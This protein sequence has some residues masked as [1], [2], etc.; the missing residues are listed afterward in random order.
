[1]SNYPDLEKENRQCE[2]ESCKDRADCHLNYLVNGE[3]STSVYCLRHYYKHH[4]RVYEKCCVYNCEIR[5]HKQFFLPPEDPTAHALGPYLCKKHCLELEN[6]CAVNDC[7]TPT[8][9]TRQAVI[10]GRK[11][12]YY[13]CE[14]HADDQV[15]LE[16]TEGWKSF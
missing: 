13:L 12:N 6:K 8:T 10:Q 16:E 14:A 15:T 9:V 7:K 1:M 3:Y 2:D 4:Y 11:I 5:V